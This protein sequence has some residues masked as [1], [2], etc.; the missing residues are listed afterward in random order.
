[1]EDGEKAEACDWLDIRP[2]I[3]YWSP[4]SIYL[5]YVSP[6]GRTSPRFFRLQLCSCS[7]TPRRSGSSL[8]KGLRWLAQDESML[9]GKVCRHP[10]S[11]TFCITCPLIYISGH[12]SFTVW[13]NYF[14]ANPNAGVAGGSSR[15]FARPVPLTIGNASNIVV[16]DI[17]ITNSPFWH[18]FVYQSTDILF[19]N[20]VARSVSF[21]SSAPSANSDGWDIYRSSY[22]TIQN[23]NINNDDDW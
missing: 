6:T 20:I 22:V 12:F 16:K 14:A 13:W 9:T 18:Q 8:G 11:S 23:S 19:D 7:K 21:N 2:D 4:N 17:S 10:W 1:M 3:S 15:T 5:T